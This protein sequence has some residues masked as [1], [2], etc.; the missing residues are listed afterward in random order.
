MDSF[1]VLGAKI[2]T[3]YAKVWP[4]EEI[5]PLMY[6]YNVNKFDGKSVK[7]TG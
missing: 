4:Y 3:V 5:I 6:M 7:L 2:Y 1:N